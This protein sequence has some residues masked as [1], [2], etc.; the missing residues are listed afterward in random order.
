MSKKTNKEKIILAIGAHPDDIDF[1]ASGT[2]AKWV[3]DGALAYYLICTN[4]NKGSDDFQMT[5]KKLAIIRCQEQQK[6][7]KI[8]GVKKVFFLNH[9]DGEL[10]PSLKL[11]EEIV[12]VVRQIKPTVVITMDPTMRYSTDRGYINH[13]D[14]IAAGEAAL[15]AVFP[16]ARDHLTFPDL[17]GRGLMPHKVKEVLMTTFDD[18]DYWVDITETIDLKIKA[19]REHPSQ[20]NDPDHMETMIK[21]WASKLARKTKS[22]YVEGFKRITLRF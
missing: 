3:K 4:G 7:A 10:R 20:I 5:S 16:F 8:L 22:K 21:E 17:I 15:S 14:H 13:P 12:K 2:I 18:P 9:N 11:K 1:S 19:L 6:A